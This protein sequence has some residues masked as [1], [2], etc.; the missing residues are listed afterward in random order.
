M[1]TPVLSVAMATVLISTLPTFGMARAQAV[2]ARCADDTRRCMIVAATSY[3]E[4]IVHHDGSKVLFAPNI[5]R[6]EQGHDTGQGEAELRAALLRMPPMLGYRNT[7]FIIDENAHQLVYFTLLRLDIQEP[8]PMPSQPG[9]SSTPGPV[10]VH[11]AERFK[12]EHG[13]ITEI[14]AIFTNQGGTADGVSGWP[15]QPR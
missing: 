8:Q 2:P 7:R 11:L 3:L 1:K 13:L 5:R 10:T 9:R 4:G 12:I 14:E 6:T 15:D